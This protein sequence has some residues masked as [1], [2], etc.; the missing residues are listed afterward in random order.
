[1]GG[2]FFLRGSLDGD[3]VDRIVFCIAI[4]PRN[5][6]NKIVTHVDVDDENVG[7]KI[8]NHQEEDGDGKAIYI[9]I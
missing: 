6:N 3:R 4:S 8:T 5:K 2:F 1:M 9:N 7:M